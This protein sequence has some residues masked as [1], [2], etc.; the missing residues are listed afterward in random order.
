MKGVN[1]EIRNSFSIKVVD[2]IQ[3]N[4]IMYEGQNVKIPDDIRASA[5]AG[6]AT[7]GKMAQKIR[8]KGKPIKMSDSGLV[9]DLKPVKV[10]SL[11]K[12][13]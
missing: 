9:G 12:I 8:S 1:A 13:T 7:I 10:L 2:A 11:V 3:E 6:A 4:S 5:K